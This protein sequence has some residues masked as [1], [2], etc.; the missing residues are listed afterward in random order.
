MANKNYRSTM[1]CNEMTTMGYLFN[2]NFK[3][4]SHSQAS[5]IA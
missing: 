3:D 4:I 1:P 5:W 2:K